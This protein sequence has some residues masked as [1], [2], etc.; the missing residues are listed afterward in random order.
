MNILGINFN[1]SDTSACILVNNELIAAVEEERFNRIKHTN[2][3]P[4]NSIEYCLQKANL[5]LNDVH[6]IA[7]NTRPLSNVLKKI[8]FS[9]KKL[10]SP[11]LA[12]RSI[13]NIKRK[14]QIKNE[15]LNNF[16]DQ[17]FNGKIIY[18]DHHLSHIASAY[19]CSNFNDSICLSIDGFGDFASLAYGFASNNEIKID[20]KIYFPHSIGIFYQAVT[21][22]LGFNKYGD[23]YKVMGLSSYGKPIYKEKLL[24]LIKIKPSCEF[25]LNLNYFNHFKKDITMNLNQQFQYKNLFNKNFENL[26]G[27]QKR[28]DNQKVE[29]FHIDLAKSA[30][31]VYE[32]YLIN[33]IKFLV[34]KYK[35]KNLCLSGGC[36]SNSVANGKILK[37][38]DIKNLYIPPAPGDAGGAVGAAYLSSKERIQSHLITASLGPSYSNLEIKNQ[39][40]KTIDKEV[41]KVLF[42]ENNLELSKKISD[43]IIEKKIIGLFYGKMEFGSRA[44]GNRSIIADPRDSNIRDIIN[45]KTKKR[46]SFRPFAPAILKEEV[47][48]WFEINHDINFMS[49]VYKFKEENKHLVPAV[50]H[51]DNTGRLQTVSK[52]NNELYYLIIKEF[53]KKTNVPIIL[54]TSFNENEPIVCSPLDAIQ[55]FLNTKIDTLILENWI[56]ER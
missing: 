55:T 29:D 53:F 6:I 44:L 1:H 30:Q 42:I 33:A 7:I 4:K 47:N 37:K 39:I 20:K 48:N 51:V 14:T 35:C 16:K 9:F 28:A 22:Y 34:E 2:A 54:N 25:Q 18:V 46:E 19:Y 31:Q 15:I 56:I 8:I 27:F 40:D 49:E 52:E 12:F 5:K 3:F 38:T 41:F 23:E 21:Q 26:I 17:E 32:D 10:I 43:L 11:N 45:A 50:C 24:E 13:K 36:A